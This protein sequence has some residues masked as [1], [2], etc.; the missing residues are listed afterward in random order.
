MIWF[1]LLGLGLDVIHP[2]A[3][4]ALER[5]NLMISLGAFGDD[6]IWIGVW[7]WGGGR[8][9]VVV[10]LMMLMFV[11]VVVFVSFIVG[12]DE[13]DTER[14]ISGLRCGWASI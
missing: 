13:Y 2:Y 4:L 12:R 1:V 9:V 8:V 14:S 6:D 5:N 3:A 7:V 10:L 11:F